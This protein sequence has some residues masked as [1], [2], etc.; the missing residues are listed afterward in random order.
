LLL[1]VVAAAALDLAV[2]VALVDL[3]RQQD[4]LSEQ[5]RPIQ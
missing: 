5:V 2:G 3:I 4:F 1:L